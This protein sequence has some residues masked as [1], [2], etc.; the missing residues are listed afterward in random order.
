MAGENTASRM[1][2]ARVVIHVRRRVLL[3]LLPASLVIG[4]VAFV[5]SSCGATL[6]TPRSPEPNERAVRV[7][8]YN[9]NYGLAGD[10]ETIAALLSTDADVVFLQETNEAWEAAL[11]HRTEHRYPHQRY[12]HAPAAGGSAVLSKRS[13]GALEMLD[14]PDGG[15]FRAMRAVVE[16]DVGPMQVLSVH[17][18]PQIGDNGSVVSGVLTTAPI[19]RREIERYADAL[20]PDM[21]TLVVGDF[22]ESGGDAVAFLEERGFVDGLALFGRADTWRWST[23]I[24]EVSSELDHVMYRAPLEPIEARVIEQGRSDH[25]PVLIVLVREEP[26]EGSPG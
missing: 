5:A 22:N 26:R 8:T 12:D 1:M 14:P 25:F 11:R 6:R 10:E 4:V 16:T 24:G 3:A 7:L 17:L 2:V 19:R 21:P 15:W 9:V 13:I 23:S 20:D 18:R